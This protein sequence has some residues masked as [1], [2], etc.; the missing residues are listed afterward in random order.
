[1]FRRFSVPFRLSLIAV[2]A[3]SLATPVSR[4]AGFSNAAPMNVARYNHT[5]TLLPNGK[6]LVAAGGTMSGSVTNSAELYD[7]TLNSWSITGSLTYARQICTATLLPSGKVLVVGGTNAGSSAYNSAELF[8]PAT[9]TW[10]ATGSLA[11]GRANHTATLLQNGQVLVVGGQGMPGVYT[12]AIGAAEIYNPS[13]NTWSSAGNLAT[14]RFN[15]TATLLSNGKV[16]VVG[17]INNSN[18]EVAN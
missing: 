10:S 16:L 3:L 7:P 1:M 14:A 4:A 2:F 18:I 8:D 13:T 6:V 12:S 5:A 17:G 11:N 15:H 9:N